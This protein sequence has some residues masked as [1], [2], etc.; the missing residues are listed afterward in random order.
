MYNLIIL[1]DFAN[2]SDVY[3][4]S[5]VRHNEFTGLKGI[6]TV[7]YWQGSGKSYAFN[8]ISKIDVKINK[9][10]AVGADV[11]HWSII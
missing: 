2:S 3:L 4:Q 5:D 11:S 10:D 1:D 7:P 6:D 9:G 8:D